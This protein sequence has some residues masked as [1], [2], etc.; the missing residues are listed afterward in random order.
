MPTLLSVNVGPAQGRR[1]AGQDRCTPA[2]GRSRSTGRGWC[3]GSTSTATGRATWRPRRR[4]AGRARL[5]DPSPTSYWQ[6]H[7]G[8]DDFEYGQFGENF[9]VDGLADDEVCIGD[10]YRIGEAEFEVTQPRVTCYRVGLRF[11]EPADARA[12]GRPSPARLLPAGHHRGPGPGRRRDRPDPDRARSA[13]RR[14]RSTRCSTCPTATT[15]QLRAA[16]RHPGAQPGL[17]GSFRDLLDRGRRPR[18]RP[19]RAERPGRPGPAS[20][21]CG[22]TGSS[23]RAPR[24]LGLPAPADGAAARRRPGRASTSRCGSPAPATRPRCAATRCPPARTR[25]ATGSASSAS[26]TAWSA[27]TC[28]PRL[29]AGARAGRRRAARRLR[30]RPRTP[31]GAADLRRRRRHPGPG[32]AA[33]AGGRARAS[34][35]VWWLHRARDRASTPSPPRRTRCWHT[36]PHAHEHVFYS[37]ATPADPAAATLGASGRPPDGGVLAELGLPADATR[38]PLRARPRS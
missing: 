38:L 18:D 11:G 9:T 35:D 34:A 31:P 33:P 36:L 30:P 28:T 7:F 19:R 13:D 4:A 22:S 12:A 10:R 1:L 8:R 6:Q 5:P 29:R 2:S 37:A 24:D 26:R 25:H 3:A 15:Q 17:A 16:L 14:R 27:A 21:S 32:D 20:G 23:A